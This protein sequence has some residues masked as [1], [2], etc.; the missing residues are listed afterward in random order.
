MMWTC[1]KCSYAYNKV[2]ANKDEVEANQ[3]SEAEPNK[4]EV[5]NMHRV[6]PKEN[7]QTGSDSNDINSFDSTRQLE[8]LVNSEVIKVTVQEIETCG[9]KINLRLTF[10]VLQT[11]I[12]EN[13]D[14]TI[15]HK[16]TTNVPSCAV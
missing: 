6:L 1:T 8:Q 7:E 14:F 12:P 16:R 9:Q 11:L 10:E 2:E 4:C 15:S 13:I 3:C 5:C